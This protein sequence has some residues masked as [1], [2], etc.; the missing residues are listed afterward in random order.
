MLLK[1]WDQQPQKLESLCEQ[2][3]FLYPIYEFEFLDSISSF[4]LTP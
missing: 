3:N 4:P 2:N 1:Y